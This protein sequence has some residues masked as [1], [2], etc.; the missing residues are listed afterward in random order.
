MSTII[1]GYLTKDGKTKCYKTGKG[2][3]PACFTN[4][5]FHTEKTKLIDLICGDANDGVLDKAYFE[6]YGLVFY[7]EK[8]NTI[9]SLQEYT[10]IGNISASAVELAAAGRYTCSGV[11]EPLQKYYLPNEILLNAMKNNLVNKAQSRT[12]TPDE[13]NTA[14]VFSKQL[15][16]K[17]NLSDYIKYSK[18]SFENFNTD[19][20]VIENNVTIVNYSSTKDGYI[21]FFEDLKVMGANIDNE[22]ILDYIND[23]D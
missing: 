15:S 1:I 11:P 12:Y 3:I 22:L 13:D 16:A 2:N 6:G 5:D 10:H 19:F 7:N 23:I 14:F 4:A 8:T 20:F 21:S 17:D 18:Q 9:H